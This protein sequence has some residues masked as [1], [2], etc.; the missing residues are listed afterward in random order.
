MGVALD[1]L[2]QA[3]AEADVEQLMAAADRQHRQVGCQGLAQ[4][5]QLELV[6][7]RG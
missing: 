7:A 3:A 5:A 4:Q 6:A 1:V 2:Q